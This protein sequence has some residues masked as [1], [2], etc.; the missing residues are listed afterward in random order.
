MA[1][2]GLISR[3]IQLLKSPTQE[4]VFSALPGIL[5]ALAETESMAP[6][7]DLYSLDLPF[8]HILNMFHA[9]RMKLHIV[10]ISLGSGIRQCMQNRLRHSPAAFM[11][12]GDGAAR[13]VAFQSSQALQAQCVAS[14]CIC[15]EMAQMI[16]NS[17][18]YAL[19]TNPPDEDNFDVRF[20]SYSSSPSSSSSSPSLAWSA[21]KQTKAKRQPCWAD[22]MRILLPLAL[23]SRFPAVLPEQ[24]RKATEWLARIAVDWGIKQ[25][26]MQY[27]RPMPWY[28]EMA[29]QLE[30]E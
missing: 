17:A 1:A 26:H 25:A 27:P 18:P 24:K 8:L 11:S 21:P 4:K 2:V 5:T 20:S 14:V 28:T 6:T 16:I 10:I 9:A 13:M 19:E 3:I 15:R 23:T 12:G 29:E 7:R 22:G 30:V